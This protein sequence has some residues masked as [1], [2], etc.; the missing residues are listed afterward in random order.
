MAAGRDNNGQNATARTRPI[1][2]KEH[3]ERKPVELV[4]AGR[5]SVDGG[6]L[7][8]LYVDDANVVV[9]GVV[10]VVVVVVHSEEGES[11][12]QKIASIN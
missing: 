12:P 3:R 1:T 8:W 11:Q 6:T 4:R 2:R 7:V 10:V 5:R 9:V